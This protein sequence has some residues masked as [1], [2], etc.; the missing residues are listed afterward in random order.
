MRWQSH[1][2]NAPERSWTLAWAD[3]DIA[4]L[5]PEIPEFTD[6]YMDV[7]RLQGCRS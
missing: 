6:D 3:L 4:S 5:T 7:G 2:A 1:C